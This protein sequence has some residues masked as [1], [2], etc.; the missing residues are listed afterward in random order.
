MEEAYPEAEEE[1]DDVA[2][3]DDDSDDVVIVGEY[4]SKKYIILL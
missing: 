1:M 2:E 3:D 4:I